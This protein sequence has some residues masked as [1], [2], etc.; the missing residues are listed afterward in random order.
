MD[1]SDR[2]YAIFS[3]TEIDK[4]DFTEVMEHSPDTLRKS[5]DGTLTFIKWQNGGSPPPDF[6]NTMTTVVGIY[7]YDEIMV[8]LAG[9]EW[10]P[11]AP[12]ETSEL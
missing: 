6:I 10:T 5:L 3:T 7:N 1:Y 8:I 11:V 2:N 4:I 9:P 12:P